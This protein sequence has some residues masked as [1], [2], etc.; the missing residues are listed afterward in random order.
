MRD[1]GARFLNFVWYRNVAAGD[2]L[3]DLM[4]DKSGALRQISLPGDAVQGRFV[5]AMREDA[6]ALLPPAASEVIVKTKEPFVQALYDLA[7][8]RMVYGRA[9]LIGDAAFVTRPHAGAATGK[10]ALNAWRLA[11]ALER[12]GGDVDRALKA[13][14]PEERRLGNAFLARNQMMGRISLVENRYNPTDPDQ[15]PGL[16]GP[17]Q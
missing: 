7:V 14:E 11:E 10:A 12:S 15:M 1:P 9:C 5:T 16:Y 2:D 13:W 6:L 8:P 3:E 17:G 4:T